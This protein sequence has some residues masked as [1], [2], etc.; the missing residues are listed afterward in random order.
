MQAAKAR[1]ILIF[2][3]LMG[4]AAMP[5]QAVAQAAANGAGSSAA[6]SLARS[7]ENHVP[8]AQAESAGPYGAAVEESAGVSQEQGKDQEQQ[9][10]KQ[11][12]VAPLQQ[13][14]DK[15]K[16]GAEALPETGSVLP[17]LSLIG[18]GVLVGGI[19]SAMKTRS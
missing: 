16:R 4:T 13:A 15:A 12:Q 8:V 18:F 19:A 1:W 6:V 5:R 9:E 2:A 7:G 14:M 3:L 10:E 11:D 17:L